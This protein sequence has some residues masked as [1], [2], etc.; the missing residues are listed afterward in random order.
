MLGIYAPPQIQEIQR[1]IMNP[2]VQNDIV[3]I[4]QINAK[5][6]QNLK[7]DKYK[8]GVP[9]NHGEL[10]T[11]SWEVKNL[12]NQPW[13]DNVILACSDTSDLKIGE[14]RVD[15]QLGSSEKGKIE[16]KFTMPN[17]TKGQDVMNLYLYLFD[18]EIKKPI[19]ETFNAK[20]IVYR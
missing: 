16:V 2:Q 11:L 9:A 20:L 1:A 4:S 13:S 17:D 7:K 8:D 19:G 12:T 10:V 15:M 5:K 3:K 14:Q 18:R 6:A